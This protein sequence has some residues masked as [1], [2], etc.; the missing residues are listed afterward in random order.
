MPRSERI[1]VRLVDLV[2]AVVVKLRKGSRPRKGTGSHPELAELVRLGHSED[3]VVDARRRAFYDVEAP[4]VTLILVVL[5]LVPVWIS[6]SALALLELR[7]LNLVLSALLVSHFIFLGYVVH[8]AVLRK[9]RNPDLRLFD[10]LLAAVETLVFLRRYQILSF[11]PSVQGKGQ[12]VKERRELRQALRWEAKVTVSQAAKLTGTT[13]EDEEYFKC[14]RIGL[15][16][17]HASKN[18][19]DIDAIDAALRECG[20]YLHHLLYNKPWTLA[21]ISA[22]PGRVE[23]LP[24]RDVLRA[25]RQVRLAIEAG[26]VTALLGAAA[27]VFAF[28]ARV[29]Q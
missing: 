23:D 9:Y 1:C 6:A 17:V 3:M 19:N 21:E 18:V 14:A 12:I 15:W 8:W 4:M 26:F 28:V 5:S 25:A 22:P 2:L 11:K 7:I 13:P 20:T 29:F 16:L 10:N 27:A 24:F